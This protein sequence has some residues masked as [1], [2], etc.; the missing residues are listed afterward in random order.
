M[1]SSDHSTRH[2]QPEDSPAQALAAVD[3]YWLPLGVG[4]HVVRFN[5]RVY[6][7]LVSFVEQ[8]RPCDLYHAA[9]VVQVPQG[10]FVIES[11]SVPDG[12]GAARGVVAGAQWGAACWAA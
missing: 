1:E 6:E 2:D 3:L 9:L 4:G 5:G 12:R 8:R 10:R 11:A 7:R